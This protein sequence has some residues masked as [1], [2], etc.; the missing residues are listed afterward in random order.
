MTDTTG[1]IDLFGGDYEHVLGQSWPA[2]SVQI[3]ALDKWSLCRL[4]LWYVVV[5][6]SRREGVA[7][8]E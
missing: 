8:P 3:S 2:S 5:G 6:S 7:R 4:P 1:S